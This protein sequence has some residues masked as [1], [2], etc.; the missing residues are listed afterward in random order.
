MQLQQ[1][2]DINSARPSNRSRKK[3]AV[4]DLESP[5]GGGGGGVNKTCMRPKLCFIT[6]PSHSCS[7]AY[8]WGLFITAL[9]QARLGKG[10]RKSTRL[11]ANYRRLFHSPPPPPPFLPA[12]VDRVYKLRYTWSRLTRQAERL[13]WTRFDKVILRMN[14]W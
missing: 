1:N 11:T 8:T 13:K 2:Y 9:T 7:L 5:P 6:S 4:I 10:V 3:A 12:C 14:L